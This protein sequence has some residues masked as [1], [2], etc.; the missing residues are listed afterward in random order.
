MKKRRTNWELFRVAKGLPLPESAV[1]QAIETS[2][3]Y[4]RNAFMAAVF[5]QQSDGLC[6]FGVIVQRSNWLSSRF[7]PHRLASALSRAGQFLCFKTM[8]SAPF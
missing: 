2:R 5:T 7:A 1:P 6:E 3:Q 4:R 8:P